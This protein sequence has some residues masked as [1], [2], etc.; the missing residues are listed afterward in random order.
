M[1][2]LLSTAALFLSFV[3]LVSF[4]VSAQAPARGTIT[5]MVTSEE[6]KVVG[7]RVAAHNLDQRLWY[8]VFTNKGRYTVPQALPGR[9]EIMVNEPAFGSPREAV[10]LR[11]GDTQ[12]VNIALDKLPDDTRPLVITGNMG[13]G[14]GAGKID[15]FKTLDE[16]YPPGPGRDLIRANCTGCHADDLTTYHYTEDRFVTGIE[17][18]TETGPAIFPNVLALGRTVFTTKEKRLMA[19]YLATHFGP[20][21]PDRRLRVDPLV[22]DEEVASKSIYVLYDIPEDVDKQK[23]TT[24]GIKIGAPM[25]DGEFEMRPGLTV[26]ALQAA[27]ISPVD[28]T[29]A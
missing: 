6:G 12:T 22:V 9:Y 16:V 10:T 5:G 1:R 4:V 20:G 8:V 25:I 18:M 2:R 19:S 21:K 15:F 27:A 29:I 11:A 14:Q 26:G 13:G 3:T 24:Q 28:G 7:L 23:A 17:K